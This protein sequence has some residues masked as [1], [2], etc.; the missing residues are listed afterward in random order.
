MVLSHNSGLPNWR[1]DYE[2]NKLFLQF[3]P[4]TDF[5]Y[6]GEGYQYLAKVIEKLLGTD[7]KGL[8]SYYQEK[9]AVPLRMNVTKFIQDESNLR[10]K[11]EPYKNGEK[12][13]KGEIQAEFG[14][15][16][17][18]HSEAGDFSKWLIALLER[19]GLSDSSYDALFKDQFIIPEGSPYR[20]EGV[21]A[22][23]LGF[24]KAEIGGNTIYGHGGNNPGYT[25]LFLIDRTKKWGLVVFT[26]A[27][28]VSE[29]GIQ[30]FMYL[31]RDS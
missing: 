7:Y 14:A 31:N 18:I 10:N 11:A 12:I 28:Q 19:E 26:N 23:T 8:E 13:P 22:W 27:N 30:L 16:Y 29:F 6:S 3:D 9:L 4:G 24:A 2:D 25:S 21:T 1:T 15:A 20:E 17:G 5:N